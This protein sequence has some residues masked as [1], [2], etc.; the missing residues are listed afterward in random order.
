MAMAHNIAFTI[1]SA[2]K[3]VFIHLYK[4]RMPTMRRSL[5]FLLLVFSCAVPMTAQVDTTDYIYR[6]DS[7]FITSIRDDNGRAIHHYARVAQY[8]PTCAAGFDFGEITIFRPGANGSD[9]IRCHFDH[10]LKSQTWTEEV[11]VYQLGTN[12]FA[13]PIQT[14]PLYF[15][16]GDTLS[17]FRDAV[18][19]FPY[20]LNEADSSFLT[21]ADDT[22]SLAIPDSVGYYIQLVNAN[23]GV[24]VADIDYSLFLPVT[25]FFQLQHC[26]EPVLQMTDEDLPF[27]WVVPDSLCDGQG[28]RLRLLPL[29]YPQ[30]RQE[31]SDRS[32]FVAFFWTMPRSDHFRRLGD[33][34][35]SAAK[36][37]ASDLAREEVHDLNKSGSFE[38]YPTVFRQGT[39]G[40][41]TVSGPLPRSESIPYSIYSLTGQ[42]VTE[43]RV[44][45]DG[46]M[47]PTAVI[48]IPGENMTRGAY[49]LL[50]HVDERYY[51][52]NFRIQ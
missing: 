11:A 17:Y 22:S 25:Q 26:I 44:T 50:L 49:F 15:E 47:P 33:S 10:P 13:N 52:R 14:R 36:R 4:F 40:S 45:T 3:D 39:M 16:Q 8:W 48:P 43:G 19:I 35:R 29:Y 41:L 12:N 34:L 24:V 27:R 5:F 21:I 42:K 20:Y 46:N 1:G 9:S 6:A 32:M 28:Y 31:F 51:F 23:S 38:V 18:F 2:I 30:L 37:Q 7:L